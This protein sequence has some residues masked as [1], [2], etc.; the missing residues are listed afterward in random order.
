MPHP[1]FGQTEKMSQCFSV[2]SH[3]RKVGKFAAFIERPKAKS[4]SSRPTAADSV[5]S[6]RSQIHIIGHVSP[7]QI[8]NTPLLR[9]IIDVQ[10]INPRQP[11]SND[12]RRTVGVVDR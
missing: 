1:P 10:A 2:F 7:C 3:V 8:L 12:C 6:A 11:G 4:V 9:L 5:G